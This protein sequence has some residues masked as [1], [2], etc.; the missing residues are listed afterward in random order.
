MLLENHDKASP[1]W[2][3]QDSSKATDVWYWST[4][5]G[6]TIRGV[7]ILSPESRVR[8]FR[9]RSGHLQPGC[10]RHCGECGFHSREAATQASRQLG[11]GGTFLTRKE[12]PIANYSAASFALQ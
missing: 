7:G 1:F 10:L 4:K 3:L 5:V 12:G 2:E 8:D 11:E 6:K 9:S